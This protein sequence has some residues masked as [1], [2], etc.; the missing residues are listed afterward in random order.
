MPTE[1]RLYT[2]TESD[3]KTRDIDSMREWTEQLKKQ[4]STGSEGSAAVNVKIKERSCSNPSC[5][6]SRYTVKEKTSITTDTPEADRKSQSLPGLDPAGYFLIKPDKENGTLT[7]EQ[8]CYDCRLIRKII[9][10]DNRA[11]FQTIINNGWVTVPGHATYLWRELGKA[12]T[13]IISGLRYV[14]DHELQ[15]EPPATGKPSAR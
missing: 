8:Y 10:S 3:E 2:I 7:V 11:I 6:Y 1:T 5:L 12:S 4:T 9:G 14:Q 15:P 13:A